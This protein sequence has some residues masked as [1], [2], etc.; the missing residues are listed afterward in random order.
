MLAISAQVGVALMKKMDLQGQLPEE[1]A[2]G[3]AQQLF[4][5]WGVGDTKCGNGAVLLLSTED[6]QVSA[7]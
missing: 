7:S 4:R 5:S 3:F 6:R 1:A 2:A